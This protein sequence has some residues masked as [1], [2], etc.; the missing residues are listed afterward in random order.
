[1]K[2][3]IFHNLPS[4]GAKRAVFEMSRVLANRGNLLHEFAFSTAD[5]NFLSIEKIASKSTIIS[6][7]W[8]PYLNHRV[9]ML[10]PYLNTI[11]G[12]KNLRKLNRFSEE[13]AKKIDS[14]NYDI[15]FVHDCRVVLNP[16]ILRYLT[17]PTVFYCH[18][19]TWK[20]PGLDVMVKRSGLEYLKDIYYSPARK[21]YAKSE[22]KAEHENI[23]WAD[24]VL[25]N[26]NF[27]QKKVLNKYGIKSEIAY[28]GVDTKKFHPLKMTKKNYVFSVGVITYRKGYRFLI[29]AL[30]RISN[31]IRPPLVIAANSEDPYELDY[32]RKLASSHHVDLHVE[33]VTDDELLV[34]LYSQASAFI[35]TSIIEP[36]GLVVLE[37]MACGTPVISVKEGGPCESI[38]D[39]ETGFLVE[40]DELKFSRAIELILTDVHLSKKLG[41]QAIDHVRQH[42][43]WKQTVDRLEH[44]FH[45]VVS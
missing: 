41:Q 7:V 25:V 32:I 36:F 44:I 20:N 31:S 26:S 27:S 37:A 5:N 18:H 14:D 34:K 21:I 33:R 39:G 13:A 8:T 15:V 19:G 24:L 29:K 42:W 4:G 1:M 3:A 6:I 16:Y 40:R 12:L 17:S 11:I 45:Q 10:T 2:I 35:F 9:P 38:I 28:L 23:K 30:G 43:T 22:T